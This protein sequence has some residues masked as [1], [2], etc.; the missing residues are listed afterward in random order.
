LA[1]TGHSHSSFLLPLCL[2]LCLPLSL[3]NMDELNLTEEEIQA[4]QDFDRFLA[5]DEDKLKELMNPEKEE[6]DEDEDDDEEEEEKEA[7]QGR[8]VKRG[9]AA[10]GGRS[11]SHYFA[12]RA[13]PDNEEE[14][15]EGVE[16]QQQ[17]Q[18]QQDERDGKAGKGKQSP[19]PTPVGFA[20]LRRGVTKEQE[21]AS[22]R[23]WQASREL[24]FETKLFSL[25][26]QRVTADIFYVEISEFGLRI[27]HQHNGLVLRSFP[28][29]SIQRSPFLPP[30][31]PSPLLHSL[32]PCSLSLLLLLLL[33]SQDA[34]RGQRGRH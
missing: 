8:G 16:Q 25:A 7:E 19:L 23:A 24:F 18:Q 26:K 27:R 4:L 29:R 21:E 3:V 17:Q 28:I 32:M 33:C 13:Q 1:C 31:P 14:E 22:I 6:E 15:E 20:T 10:G 11:L 9:G 5:L 2:P 12:A 34:L 30:P